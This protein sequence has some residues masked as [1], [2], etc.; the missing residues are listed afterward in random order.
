MYAIINAGGKQHRVV[1]G[2]KLRIDLMAGK[3]KGDSVTFD[4]VL[5][6]KTDGGYKV[7]TPVV[8]GASVSATVVNNGDDG[9]GVKGQ[10]VLVF[11]KKRRK[12]YHKL[13]GH[14]QRYTEVK[15]EKISA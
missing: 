11:K 9:E 15:I 1:E 12:G 10:K 7:G 14:R 13:R 3:N 6:V 4:Q 5:M 2:E 8:D